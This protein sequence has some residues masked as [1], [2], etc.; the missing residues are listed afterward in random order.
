[1][2]PPNPVTAPRATFPKD[3]L[4]QSSTIAS[5]V[6]STVSSTVD[7]TVTPNCRST[8]SST[9]DSTVTPTVTPNCRSTVSSTVDSTVT[10]TVTPNCRSTVSSTVTPTIVSTVAS[11]VASTFVSTFVTPT[12]APLSAPLSTRLSPRLS[13]PL[14]VTLC[15]QRIMPEEATLRWVVD[16]KHITPSEELYLDLTEDQ[17]A[18]R[19]QQIHNE[20]TKLE[21][22]KWLIYQRDRLQAA[23]RIS[24]NKNQFIENSHKRYTFDDL[25]KKY[26]SGD[27]WEIKI[28]SALRPDIFLL[29][30]CT[31]NKRQFKSISEQGLQDDFARVI[32]KS[33]EERWKI[34][35][36]VVG[37]AKSSMTKFK[38]KSEEEKQ[39][40]QGLEPTT[41]SLAT[42]STGSESLLPP[43]TGLPRIP[44]NYDILKPNSTSTTTALTPPDLPQPVGYMQQ[45]TYEQYDTRA[46]KSGH[47]PWDG[48]DQNNIPRR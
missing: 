43:S 16:G 28:L 23:V 26:S 8:V 45:N 34:P 36:W 38:F 12:V 1:M 40:L 5:T 13:A 24:L 20:T 27:E 30:C 11:A 48:L 29:L 32:N 47:V 35:E 9:V 14:T 4:A 31:F 7:S 17:I 18:D 44:P 33:L 21:K 15:T 6:S 39:L 42:H 3:Q 25:F 10:P 19:E 22:S 41:P 37:R 2:T 46:T